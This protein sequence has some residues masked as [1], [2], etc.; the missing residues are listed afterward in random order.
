LKKSKKCGENLD[1]S[2]VRKKFL[3]EGDGMHKDLRKRFREVL[4]FLFLFFS[5]FLNRIAVNAEFPRAARYLAWLIFQTLFFLK[6]PLPLEVAGSVKVS[7]CWR[8][9]RKTVFTIY[10]PTKNIFP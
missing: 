2:L 10:L 3:S 4:S 8:L 1:I 6:L 9:D 5:S 7:R